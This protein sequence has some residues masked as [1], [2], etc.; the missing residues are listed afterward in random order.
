MGQ[1]LLSESVTVHVCTVIFVLLAIITKVFVMV[2]VGD[3]CSA[4]TEMG[5]RFYL[6]S[7]HRVVNVAVA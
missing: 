1:E 4:T 5:N 6:A 7:H 3:L 2:I